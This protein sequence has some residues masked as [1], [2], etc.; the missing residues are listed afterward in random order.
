M[1]PCCRPSRGGRGLCRPRAGIPSRRLCPSPRRGG[2]RGPPPPPPVPLPRRPWEGRCPASRPRHGRLGAPARRLPPASPP[3]LAHQPLPV[4]LA[5]VGAHG[6]GG[7]RRRA[8]PPAP[9][10]RRGACGERRGLRPPLAARR[11]P[12]SGVLGTGL[13]EPGPGRR[14]TARGLGR[15]CRAPAAS[16]RRSL[17]AGPRW[18][19]G[20][21]PAQGPAEVSRC[22]GQRRVFLSLCGHPKEPLGSV[23]T[24][25]EQPDILLEPSVRGRASGYCICTAIQTSI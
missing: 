7:P 11:R 24:A 22:V 14:V 18:P 13:P 16:T 3:H 12:P 17:R 5:A 6:S 9:A 25:T 23:T 20:R 1:P 4:A 10:F 21:A 8:A 2:S 19:G 15:L